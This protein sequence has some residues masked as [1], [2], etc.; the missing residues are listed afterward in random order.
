MIITGLSVPGKILGKVIPGVIRETM[1]SLMKANMFMRG[2]SCLIKLVSFYDQVA[3][4]V[5]QGKSVDV[6]GLDFCKTFDAVS[7]SNLLDKMSS[8]QLGN[9]KI[10][11][12]NNCLTSQTQNVLVS[13]IISGWQTVSGVPP[14][15]ISGLGILNVLINGLDAGIECT[16]SEYSNDTKQKE[17]C[18]YP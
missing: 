18:L 12:V 13:R 8:T 2:K 7:Q 14:G 5:D 15:S 10:C 16:L 3:H 17:L 6:V 1:H 11:W 9:S 4:L